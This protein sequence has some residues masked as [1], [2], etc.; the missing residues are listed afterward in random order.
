MADAAR[1]IVDL[2]C[3]CL[4]VD[5]FTRRRQPPPPAY[6]IVVYRQPVAANGSAEGA[7]HLPL[8]SCT[9]ERESSCK[10]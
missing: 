5:V 2:L 7:G 10:Q 6:P 1:A 3:C 4:L 9:M 8:I